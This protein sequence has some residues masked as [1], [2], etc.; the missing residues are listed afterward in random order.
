[1][2]FIRK[3]VLVFILDFGYKNFKSLFAVNKFTAKRVTEV[4][5]FEVTTSRNGAVV[6]GFHNIA[7][8]QG[9]K[10]ISCSVFRQDSWFQPLKAYS[11]FG[12]FSPALWS[13]IF[14]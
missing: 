10:P 14:F 3:Y 6:S 13:A 7:F 8:G 4:S 1:M 9:G 12:S 11:G 5:F 2:N